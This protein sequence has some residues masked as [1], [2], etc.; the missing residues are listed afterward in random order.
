MDNEN[1]QTRTITTQIPVKWPG[2]TP[3]IS[4]SPDILISV[5]NGDAFIIYSLPPEE[6]ASL[7]KLSSQLKTFQLRVR[8]SLETPSESCV[9]KFLED[10]LSAKWAGEY[11]IWTVKEILGIC[12]CG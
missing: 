12:E 4:K 7:I 2:Y 5:H 1:K 8:A 11:K 3:I 9:T 6:M 10:K